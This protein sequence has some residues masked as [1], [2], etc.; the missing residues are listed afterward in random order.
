[1][2]ERMNKCKDIYIYIYIFAFIHTLIH[3]SLCVR[4][5]IYVHVRLH[6]FLCIELTMRTEPSYL[7]CEYIYV[8]LFKYKHIIIGIVYNSELYKY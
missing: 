2:Y 8:N 1:M 6:T 4:V 3:V 5:Y 7:L